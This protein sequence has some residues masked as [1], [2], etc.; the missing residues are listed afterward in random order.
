LRL[1]AVQ[2]YVEITKQEKA[3]LEAAKSRSRPELGSVGNP[4]PR[5]ENTGQF[6][7]P[8][9]MMDGESEEPKYG[10]S[11]TYLTDRLRTQRPDIFE[12]LERGKYPSVRAAAREAGFVRQEYRLPQDPTDAGKYLAKRVDREWLAAMIAAFYEK[13]PSE[14]FEVD[15]FMFRIVEPQKQKELKSSASLTV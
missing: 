13:A 4:G 10:T 5:D 3:A 6:T 7:K 9:D 14:E 1:Q 15:D 12:K 11:T 8:Y 2:S